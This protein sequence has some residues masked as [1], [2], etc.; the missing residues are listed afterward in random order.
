M[1]QKSEQKQ[2]NGVRYWLFA[3]ASAVA[4]FAV[5]SV[6]KSVSLAAGLTFAV[7]VV[8]IGCMWLKFTK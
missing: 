7:I 3:F 5:L 4:V 1:T 6:L 2:P 8:V